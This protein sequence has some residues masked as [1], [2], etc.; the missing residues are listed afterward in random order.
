MKKLLLVFSAFLALSLGGCKSDPQS[1]SRSLEITAQ[2]SSFFGLKKWA[3]T[4]P[5]A[6]R[7]CAAALKNN[8]DT[9]LLPYLNGTQLKSS[10]EVSAL[11]SSSLFKKVDPD[12]KDVIEAAAFVLDELLP[13]PAA[14]IYLKEDQV[15]YVKCF[16]TGLK[17]GCD[18]FIGKTTKKVIR[19][20]KWVDS[21]KASNSS[22]TEGVK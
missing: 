9:E 15:L 5:E 8:I 20:S 4:K 14:D 19:K 12:I 2:A 21:D 13:V 18:Q 3:K 7:E 10:A 11:L 17:E 22:S 6:A 1:I 16:I